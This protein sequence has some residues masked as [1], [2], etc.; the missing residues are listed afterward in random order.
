MGITY[1]PVTISFLLLPCV[2]FCGKFQLK[3]DFQLTD[4]NS[5]EQTE[6][7]PHEMCNKTITENESK[8]RSEG[9][10]VIIVKQ[11][12]CEKNIFMLE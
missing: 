6:A 1:L 7:W 5:N 8:G 11:L 12:F 3:S 10:I 9:I 4:S 2:S